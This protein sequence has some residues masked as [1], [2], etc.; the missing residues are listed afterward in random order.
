M[1]E[2]V[3]DRAGA[4]V[5]DLA[6]SRAPRPIAADFVGAVG[7]GVVHQEEAANEGEIRASFEMLENQ[8]GELRAVPYEETNVEHV[9]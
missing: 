4:H 6:D 5:H 7:G 3:R 8:R 2:R 9:S 1:V